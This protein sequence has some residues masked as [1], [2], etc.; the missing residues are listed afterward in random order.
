MTKLQQAMEALERISQYDTDWTV[1]PY[2]NVT[3]LQAIAETALSRLNTASPAEPPKFD[4]VMAVLRDPSIPLDA[5]E[6]TTNFLL[7]RGLGVVIARGCKKCMAADFPYWHP[8]DRPCPVSA[9]TP[10]SPAEPPVVKKRA[11]ECRCRWEEGDPECPVHAPAGPPIA[12][13]TA[14]ETA[15][16][17][18]K[19]WGHVV[20]RPELHG[21]LVDALTLVIEA[22]RS[23]SPAEPQYPCGCCGALRTKGQGV[24]TFTVC[25]H[26]YDNCMHGRPHVP[27]SPAELPAQIPVASPSGRASETLAP[28]GG[29]ETGGSYTP[30]EPPDTKKRDAGCRCH[31]EEGDSE[32]PVHDHAGPPV[33]LRPAR[34]A[35]HSAFVGAHRPCSHNPSK[36]HGA[37]C[38]SLTAMLEADRS[39]RGLDPAR[40]IEILDSLAAE[41]ETARLYEIPGGQKVSR[42]PH[43]CGLGPGKRQLLNRF[44]ADMR[45][46][47]TSQPGGERK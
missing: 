26:C 31:R 45:E 37:L 3:R 42:T 10:A 32:C 13:R 44:I 28:P 8:A 29:G 7:Q 1:N 30:A 15:E 33:A 22:D 47:L 5:D 36:Y 14:R 11:V 34:E 21:Q 4:E 24:T 9:D 19:L 12:P 39:Q 23:A 43:W 6:G 2:A 27:A 20:A 35:V 46:A 17:C 38:D 25:D 41:I 18:A 40:A 16:T